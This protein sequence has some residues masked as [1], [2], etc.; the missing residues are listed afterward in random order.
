M[1]RLAL[2]AALLGLLAAL[3]GGAA[4]DAQ[5]DTVEVRIAARKAQDG[6]VELCLELAEEP[7]RRCPRAR[8]FPYAQAPVDRWLQSSAV[9]HGAA[10][11]RVRVR[12]NADGRIEVALAVQLGGAVR[13][14]MPERRFFSWQAAAVDRWLRS[15]R[16]SIRAAAG[17][18]PPSIGAGAARLQRGQPAPNFTLPRL[19]GGGSAALSDFSGKTVV[20]VFWASWNTGDLELLRQLDELWRREGGAKG[21]LAV[22]AINVYDAPGA[23]ARAFVEASLGIPSLIDRDAAAA[24]HYRIDGLPELLLIDRSGVYR[25]RLTGA[26]DTAALAAAL[27]RTR[28]AVP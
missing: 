21:D 14:I 18:I 8:F 6:R 2:A 19:E 25:E 26:A 11:L 10:S 22:L 5:G 9:E 3:L 17:Q 7:Q 16:A 13:T 12:R 1:A 23:A 15:S 28:G 24:V 20:L 27:A 4:V